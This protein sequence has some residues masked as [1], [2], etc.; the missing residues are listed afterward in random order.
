MR[1]PNAYEPPQTSM[2]QVD[3]FDMVKRSKAYIEA[4]DIFQVVVSQRFNID[5]DLERLTPCGAG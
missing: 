3:Y 5:Y 2:S 1:L 4:G